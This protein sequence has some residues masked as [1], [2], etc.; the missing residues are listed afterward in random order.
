MYPIIKRRI[1]FTLSLLLFAACQL[2]LSAKKHENLKNWNE[3]PLTWADYQKVELSPLASDFAP[4]VFQFNASKKRVRIQNYKFVYY[5]VDCSLNKDKSYYDPNRTDEWDLR[6]RQAVF[7]TWELYSR[8]AQSRSLG[9]TTLTYNKTV[10]DY[11]NRAQKDIAKFQQESNQFKDTAVI[12]K[13]G[14]SVRNQL[15]STKRKTPD[16]S[17]ADVPA[18]RYGVYIG[19]EH[20]I[21]MGKAGDQLNNMYGFNVGIDY[22][23]KRKWYLDFGMSANFTELKVDDFY[24][25]VGYAYDWVT[26][27]SVTN[28]RLYFNVGHLLDVNQ[29]LR[30]IPFAGISYSRLQQ[31]S[32]MIDPSSQ[33]YSY[34]MSNLNCM[35][36]QAGVNADFMIRHSITPDDITDTS[37][38]FKLYG[39]YEDWG[40]GHKAYSVNL[41]L[42]IKFDTYSFVNGIFIPIIIL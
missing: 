15:E 22:I 30:F 37:I 11:M 9:E 4:S 24:H 1:V 16:L 33:N 27:K 18:Y 8:Y 6:A 13:Y 28:L 29:Y 3:G 12:N 23:T 31:Q 26:Y 41:G 2:Q 20:E 19:A 7:D 34:L 25:D 17:M 5:Q 39:A 42:A 10:E 38:R 40:T 14:A 32:D 36:V 35:A 21:L